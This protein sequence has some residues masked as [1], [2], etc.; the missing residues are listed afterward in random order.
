MPDAPLSDRD[1]LWS[2]G[3]STEDWVIRF[4]VGDD[5][6]W[7]KLL[8]PYDARGT[9][10]HARG[11]RQIGLLSKAEMQDIDGALDALGAAIDAGEVTITPQDEDAHTVIERFLTARLGDTGKKIHTGRSRNDQVLTA[12]RLFLKDQTRTLGRGCADL[13]E[14]LARLSE[15][16]ATALM[17]GYTHYQRAMPTTAGLWALAYAEVL[18]T[19]LT[20]LHAAFDQVDTS[21]LGSA[22]GYGVP[23]LDLPR[24]DTATALGFARLQ[25][26]TP[27]VQLSRGKTEL[28]VAH[29]CVQV[30][31]TINRLASDLVLYNSAEFGF[32]R[33]P[34][35]FTTGSS[36]MPQ[37]RNPDVLELA[38]A[39][40]HRL[41]AEHSVLMTLPANLPSGYHRDLQ[42]TK[43]AVMRSVMLTADLLQA[44]NALVPALVFDRERMQAALSPDLIA[45]AHALGKVQQ[46]MPFREAYRQAAAELP[47]LVLPAPEALLA[48]YVSDGT[49][50]HGRPDFIRQALSPHRTGWLSV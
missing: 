8:L 21:P 35:S 1:R 11:L 50:G 38:R 14:A 36:I 27:A 48:S 42:L 7:D 15:E 25:L 46:G 19:D 33:L 13:A 41:M 23:L 22:A 24:R 45:T 12:L 37:K 6:L 30:G 3:Q 32:V 5:Y 20:A 39:H 49:P 47:A 10:A 31:A 28:H 4:T 43:E 9:R 17:P 26:H 44:M 18:T 2:K 29:A 16:Y 34:H 40:Y